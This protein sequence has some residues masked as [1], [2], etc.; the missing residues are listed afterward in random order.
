[1]ASLTTFLKCCEKSRL[2]REILD[3]GAGGE[4]PPLY[5]F[6]LLGYE[7]RGIDISKDQLKKAIVFCQE[8][9]T[10]L[11]IEEGDM[12]DLPF[13]EESFNFVYSHDTICH[14]PKKEVSIAMQEM[15]RVLKRKGLLYVNFAATTHS[16]YG[17]GQEVGVGEFVQNSPRGKVHISYYED[18]E[19]DKYFGGLE[20]LCKEKRTRQLTRNGALALG[21]DKSAKAHV[22][23]SLDY[24]ARKNKRVP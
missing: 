11:N 22:Y 17:K 5:I 20:I 24:I 3:C 10:D 15:K 23:A 7:T 14:M 4:Q 21:Y 12:R 2:K 13:K 1:M 16:G 9:G 8:K 6:H 18:D 19:P